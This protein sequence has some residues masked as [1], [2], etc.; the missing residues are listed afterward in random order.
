MKIKIYQID[1]DK[2]KNNVKFAR[3]ELLQKYQGSSEIDASLYKEVFSGDVDCTTLEGVYTAFN[4]TPHPLHRGH[5]LSVSDIVTTD[6]GAFYCDSFGFQKVDFDE[7][8]AF[9]PDN[10]LKIVY[11]EPHKP[12]V[13]A[14][15]ENTSFGFQRAV[16]GGIEEI[17]VENGTVLIGN[18]SAKIDKMDGNRRYCDGE[19]IIAGPFFAVGVRGD[20]SEDYFRSLTDEEAQTYMERFAEPEEISQEEVERDIGIVMRPW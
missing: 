8:K 16:L 15:I 9:K 17:W 5:S 2:D 14:E 19:K 4:K 11:V 6:D 20:D 3:H 18:C 7:S 12:P 1:T 10:L 13:L